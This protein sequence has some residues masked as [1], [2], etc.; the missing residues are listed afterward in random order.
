MV[1]VKW[2]ALGALA[3]L[4][5]LGAAI[6]WRFSEQILRVQLAEFRPEFEIV[7]VEEDAVV[8]PR[9][10]RTGL[11]GH[12][13][14]RWEGGRGL[15][16]DIL[17]EDEATVR[18][19]L[20]ALEGEAP[21]AGLPA[22]MDVYL[23]GSDPRLAHG[24]PFESLRLPGE[25]GDLHAWWLEG[26]TD[27]AVVMLHGRGATRHESLR[28]LPAVVAGGYGALLLAYRNH[29][30]SAP[31]PDGFHH[32]GASEWRD[33]VT[34]VDYLAQTRSIGRVVL[35]GFSMGGAVALEAARQLE[36][37]EGRGASNPHL[38]GIILDAPMLDVH[39]AIE[40]GAVRM[41]VPWPGLLSRLA[42]GVARLRTGIDW[43]TLDKRRTLREVGAPVLLIHG[44]ADTVTPI[45]VSDEFAALAP[46]QVRYHRVPGAGHVEAWNQDPE[47]YERW[48]RDFLSEVAGVTR[49]VGR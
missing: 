24:Y 2:L 39:A 27:T 15:V 16:G 34:A 1:L 21:R 17:A 20:E 18:R 48:I 9:T 44:T 28:T 42:L 14:L 33:V 6:L 10:D 49:S 31:S 45:A 38:A 29:D 43:G 8:L 12:Y 22:A 41:G 40:Q 4:L 13:G 47:S 19:R 5:I 7:A 30:D 35:Y 25:A 36:R 37:R 32:Y 3:V 11:R 26:E 23:Y 46:E